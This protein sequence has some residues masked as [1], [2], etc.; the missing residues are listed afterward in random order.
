MKTYPQ[1]CKITTWRWPILFYATPN[2]DRPIINSQKSHSFDSV[3]C[4]C[5]C[6]IS[7]GEVYMS[8][9]RAQIGKFVI[10]N[11]VRAYTCSYHGRKYMVWGFKIAYLN[12]LSRKIRMVQLLNYSQRSDEVHFYLV[13]VLIWYNNAYGVRGADGAVDSAIVI[14]G[15]HP[16]NHAYRIS[17]FK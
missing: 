6:K 13:K 5:L 8:V 11:G 17:S 2:R 10:E 15:A 12:E 9:G 14:A 4:Y 1:A 16:E 3:C 7:V